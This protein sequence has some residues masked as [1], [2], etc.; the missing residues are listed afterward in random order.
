MNSPSDAPL[1]AAASSPDMHPPK[2]VIFDLGKVLLDFDYRRTARAMAAHCSLDEMEI[3]A[4]MLEGTLLLRYETGL[5]T[6]GQFFDEMKQASQFRHG[7]E[8]FAGLFSDIFDPIPEMIALNERLRSRNV[9]TYIFSNT[10]ELAVQHIRATY[11]FFA[12][13]TNYIYSF[14][15]RSMKPDPALYDVVEKTSGHRG[16]DLLYID[17][18]PENIAQAA[19]RGWQTIH[20]TGHPATVARVERL[21]NSSP[22]PSS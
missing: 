1:K 21:L 20:H 14:E 9:P 18:R 15:H 11:P 5:I 2:A 13:F 19:E 6:T 3:A 17:D 10:N 16:P 8:Q 7:L 4:A 12:N 22:G